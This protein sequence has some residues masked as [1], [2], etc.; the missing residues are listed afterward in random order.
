[1]NFSFMP[2]YGE[3]CE[4]ELTWIVMEEKAVIAGFQTRKEAETLCNYFNDIAAIDSAMIG[5]PYTVKQPEMA[6]G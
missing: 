2:W 6:I 4:H 5:V 1:M 3:H